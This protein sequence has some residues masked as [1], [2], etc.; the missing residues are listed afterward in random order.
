M[1]NLRHFKKIISI[2][3]CVS[4]LLTSF[5]SRAGQILPA[6]KQSPAPLGTAIEEC[7]KLPPDVHR[8]TAIGENYKL[9]AANQ[10]AEIARAVSII[11]RA[12]AAFGVVAKHEI[13]DQDTLFDFVDQMRADYCSQIKRTGIEDDVMWLV[14]ATEDE[15]AKVAVYVFI[16]GEIF[17]RYVPAG[18]DFTDEFLTVIRGYGELSD[19]EMPPV[20]QTEVG[21]FARQIYRITADTVQVVTALKSLM[22]QGVEPFYRKLKARIAAQEIDFASILTRLK[23][24][25]EE[26]SLEVEVEVK[27]LLA[28]FCR[29]YGYDKSQMSEIE[30]I[31]E[32][33]IRDFMERYFFGR[34]L[35]IM[36]E[37]GTQTA[38][39][40]KTEEILIGYVTGTFARLMDLTEKETVDIFAGFLGH[41]ERRKKYFLML[42]LL[43]KDQR[44]QDLNIVKERKPLTEYRAGDFVASAV[45]G[46][47][48]RKDDIGAMDYSTIK[49][50]GDRYG[51]IARSVKLIKTL[52]SGGVGGAVKRRRYLLK[53]RDP[54]RAS[55]YDQ[56]TTDEELQELG[57][58]S[59]KELGSKDSD[60]GFEIEIDGQKHW[61]SIM[62]AKLIR[63]IIEAMRGDYQA[64]EYGICGSEESAKCFWATLEKTCPIDFS[65]ILERKCPAGLAGVR[66]YREILESDLVNITL[67]WQENNGVQMGIRVP[68]IAEAEDVLTMENEGHGNHG[69]RAVFAMLGARREPI[70][71][72]ETVIRA[73]YNGDGINNGVDPTI[74]GWMAEERVPLVMVTTEKTRLDAKGGLIGLEIVDDN[75]NYRVQL[76]ELAQAKLAE[77]EDVFRDMG[78]V[79]GEK[80]RQY[81]NTNT[82]LQN[83]SI[84][85][86]FLNALIEIIGIDEFMQAMSPVLI[87]N[88]KEKDGK[89]F[90]QLEG[91][92]GSVLLAI[93]GYVDLMAKE[94]PRVQALKDEHG[95]DKFLRIVNVRAGNRNRFF[96]PLKSAV[97]FW[98]LFY[99]KRFRSLLEYM[100]LE[101]QHRDRPLPEFVLQAE[102]YADVQNL[103]DAFAEMDV[104][105]LESL[106]ISGRPVFLRNTQLIQKVSIAHR[107][108]SEG[109]A[110]LSVLD[111][112]E[113]GYID[114]E[115]KGKTVGADIEILGDSVDLSKTKIKGKVGIINLSGQMVKLHDY[116]HWLIEEFGI[117][118]NRADGTLSLSNMCI[119]I[120]N[121]DVYAFNIEEEYRE[122]K[123]GSGNLARQISKLKAAKTKVP[124]VLVMAVLSVYRLEADSI[125]VE[126]IKEPENNEEV[127]D[128]IIPVTENPCPEYDADCQ[129]RRFEQVSVLSE[130]DDP[131]NLLGGLR[132]R[133]SEWEK[134]GNPFIA[135][136]DNVSNYLSVF[137]GVNIS[138]LRYVYE[139]EL[140]D[141]AKQEVDAK[142]R[143]IETFYGLTEEDALAQAMYEVLA[144]KIIAA[145][146]EFSA[147][148]KPVFKPYKISFIPAD[149]YLNGGRRQVLALSV[150]PETV[151]DL[152]IVTK[153]RDRIRRETGMRDSGSF[154]GC[155]Q[156]GYLVRRMEDFNDYEV[157][158]DVIGDLR[159]FLSKAKR[160]AVLEVKPPISVLFANA[161]KDGHE[162]RAFSWL[163]AAH[164]SVAGQLKPRRIGKKIWDLREGYRPQAGPV[165]KKVEGGAEYAELWEIGVKDAGLAQR[166]RKLTGTEHSKYAKISQK[167]PLLRK[168]I[169]ELVE[170]CGP[171]IMAVVDAVRIV[172]N[173]DARMITD[174]QNGIV[175]YAKI[176]RESGN[177]S[178]LLL[179]VDVLDNEQLLH[180]VLEHELK[181]A[182]M[183]LVPYQSE[184]IRELTANVMSLKF[185]L[186]LIKRNELD[187]NKGFFAG[188]QELDADLQFFQALQVLTEQGVSSHGDN[189]IMLV[190]I[191]YMRRTPHY[192]RLF[193]ELPLA[194]EWLA[195][196]PGVED[197]RARYLAVLGV[198]NSIMRKD[199][200]SKVKLEMT[201][202]RTLEE[203]E[204]NIKVV[205]TFSGK[206]RIASGLEVFSRRLQ[207]LVVTMAKAVWAKTAIRDSLSNVGQ[208]AGEK[209]YWIL[210]NKERVDAVDSAI[211]NADVVQDE[212]NALLEI[213][214]GEEE[215]VF[216]VVYDIGGIP[217]EVFSEENPRVISLVDLGDVNG[218]AQNTSMLYFP[219]LYTS[220]SILLAAQL[221]VAGGK[222]S[223]IRDEMARGIINELCKVVLDKEELT[224]A[225]LHNLF[226]QPWT[227]VSL[228][229]ELNTLRM[230]MIQLEQAA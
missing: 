51:R 26:N 162:L 143:D 48:G 45:C 132:G 223:E 88:Q 20:L 78:L 210:L 122:D 121:D 227:V 168:R 165:G 212:I 230:A 205:K 123:L 90:Y 137:T 98:Y 127:K 43:Y 153:I 101:D 207:K 14:S 172:D 193:D 158:K 60:M 110:E 29:K 138:N 75:G 228:T 197:V 177:R 104:S 67:R 229:T 33:V 36:G 183:T 202:E 150:L 35:K 225:D 38:L 70:A 156:L 116:S 91:A 81:F 80:K 4:F 166:G 112:C 160:K 69:L 133:A 118:L 139:N 151:E 7:Y 215:S 208:D 2:I 92:M 204:V 3:V 173:I 125:A 171:G 63:A 37:V 42:Y 209:K 176:I 181:E 30:L 149:P 199:N 113:F 76:L 12:D 65:K 72:G 8:G 206:R 102:F 109:L 221:V 39:D 119:V 95:I 16:E 34:P 73:I 134:A 130:I 15:P 164:N 40:L 77:Q 50:D 27:N 218:I 188:L 126:K 200:A 157:F 68:A 6:D 136:G 25:Y 111:D 17:I 108:G 131:S 18:E 87:K 24:H 178:V 62:E 11:G 54:A 201:L 211:E 5:S 152:E 32:M 174:G 120:N 167:L 186:E 19:G 185:A 61:I 96:T 182:I 192:R 66:T 99:S 163:D 191:E 175:P 13:V 64:V 142:K 170:L 84:L 71:E 159:F 144:E 9:A 226:R 22:Q 79:K 41:S 128:I 224:V 49:V 190:A 180:I 187:L 1:I 155:I 93:A 103:I 140:F 100:K 23:E 214:N 115:D 55:Q 194:K 47:K 129:P 89:K 94:D 213:R 59:D 31:Q 83:I 57:I 124:D 222:L 82:A 74:V 189:R 106:K 220:G 107:Y 58:L 169:A 198:F 196:V 114:K 117:E 105:Q 161:K 28:G 53:R 145:L 219:A 147:A 179:D 46:D 154:R 21:N 217:A 216:N 97:D 148:K 86:P 85:Q 135:Y 44:V 141:E 56:T 10:Y 146:K 195:V 184:G 203:V 52:N